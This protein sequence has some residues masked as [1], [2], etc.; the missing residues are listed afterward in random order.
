MNKETKKLDLENFRVYYQIQYERIDHL[1]SRRENFCNFV[2]TISSGILALAITNTQN[3][4]WI[5]SLGMLLFIVLI[6]LIAIEFTKSTM[7]YI[8][9]H[10]KRAK[11]AI[12]KYDPFLH[13]LNS[14][15]VKPDPKIKVFKKEYPFKRHNIYQLLHYAIIFFFCLLTIYLSLKNL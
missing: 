13:E 3:F 9:M 12:I 2:L 1:E 11:D 14:D 5:L 4:N 10:Q 15:I 7:P 8:K 6:N